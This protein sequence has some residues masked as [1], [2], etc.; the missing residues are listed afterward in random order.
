MPQISKLY[1]LVRNFIGMKFAQTWRNSLF[2]DI[3]IVQ[4]SHGPVAGYVEKDS[5]HDFEYV[6]FSGIPYAEPPIGPLRF[7]V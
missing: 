4:T 6:A 2:P 5:K 3:I 1:P 7:K